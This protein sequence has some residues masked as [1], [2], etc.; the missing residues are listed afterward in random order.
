MN[1]IAP[2]TIDDVVG[3]GPDPS[4][5]PHCGNYDCMHF[6]DN[7]RLCG[8]A[9]YV[10]STVCDRHPLE[11]TYVRTIVHVDAHAGA[12]EALNNLSDELGYEDPRLVALRD[13]LDPLPEEDTNGITPSLVTGSFDRLAH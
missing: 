8:R 6:E 13:A 9:I 2:R 10:G 12:V 5:I 11:P 3:S 4:G 7:C 1:T